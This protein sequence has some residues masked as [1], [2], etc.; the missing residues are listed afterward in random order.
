MKYY[1]CVA[2]ALLLSF[3]ASAQHK[4]RGGAARKQKVEEPEEDPRITQMLNSVQQVVFIDS[5]V[6][7]A[8]SYMSHIPLSP[9]SGKLTQQGGVGGTFTNEMGDRR[10]ATVNNGGHTTIA[11]SDFIANRWTDPLPV[12]GIGDDAAM[13]PFLMPDGI[14]LY[15]AQKGEKSIG[16]YDIFLTRYDSERGSYLKPENVGMPFASEANDLFYAVDEFNQL[17]YFVTDRRQP[18]GKVCIYVFIPKETR[19]AYNT[20]AYSHEQL[21][22]L[23]NI[24]RIADSWKID[25][26]QRME[27]QKRLETARTKGGLAKSAQH[28][29]QLTEL[30]KLR[31]EAEVL[32]KELTLTRNR[33]ALASVSERE[34]MRDRI[35]LSEQ[36]LERLQQ[37]I[38]EKE[39][40]IPYNSNN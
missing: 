20:D 3:S 30:D 27:A 21:Q 35:L 34:K 7:D 14:T 33:Y 9:Y 16:G 18:E 28:S 26:G 2:L 17:G 19:R 5:L 15:F 25:T 4:G 10:L 12:D 22:R 1:I 40:T 11:N 31:H 6:V 32:E 36:Q 29:N 39:K 8:D 38:M 13:N 24:S 23:A 37:E